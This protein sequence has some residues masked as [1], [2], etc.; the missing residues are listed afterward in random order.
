MPPQ[1]LT[2]GLQLPTF[3]SGQAQLNDGSG[4]LRVSHVN[5]TMTGVLISRRA[6][7]C[8]L[9]EYNSLSEICI[10][11]HPILTLCGQRKHCDCQMHLSK[12]ATSLMLMHSS[13]A[14]CKPVHLLYLTDTLWSSAAT[15]AAV[16][17]PD[18]TT[19]TSVIHVVD[20]VLLPGN[21]STV[22]GAAGHAPE[23]VVFAALKPRAQSGEPMSDE[24]VTCR[25]LAHEELRAALPMSTSTMGLCRY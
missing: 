10:K 12:S 3:L 2:H 19:C 5:D 24:L 18:V 25:Q 23:D 21:V 11:A 8:R 15:T 22:S 1:E 13:S 6:V 14:L 4:L 17:I 20:G 7:T 9:A 16:L